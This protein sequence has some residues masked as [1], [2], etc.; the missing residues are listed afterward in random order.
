M[1]E[2]TRIVAKPI[3]KDKITDIKTPFIQFGIALGV[4]LITLVIVMII[5]NVTHSGPFAD[6]SVKLKSDQFYL[7]GEP[8]KL[9]PQ[10]KAIYAA[11]YKQYLASV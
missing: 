2:K 7:Y 4:V 1:A 6:F 3:K 11:L 9:T 10:E 5:L 8:K